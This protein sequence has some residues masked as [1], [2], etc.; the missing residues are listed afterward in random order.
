MTK[1][2]RTH[3]YVEA[4]IAQRI[5]LIDLGIPD[6]RTLDALTAEEWAWY[7]PIFKGAN[8]LWN[9]L[10]DEEQFEAMGELDA[11]YDVNS[12]ECD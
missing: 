3:K 11:K 4:E 2:R 8:D 6:D 9:R 1:S 5:A 7:E 12:R 10:S